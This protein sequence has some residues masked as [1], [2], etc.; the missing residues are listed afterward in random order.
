MTYLD[1]LHALTILDGTS[2][3]K[4]RGK[5]SSRIFSDQRWRRPGIHPLAHFQPFQHFRLILLSFVNHLAFQGAHMRIFDAKD[6]K[7]GRWTI[8]YNTTQY[9]YFAIYSIFTEILYECSLK[10]KLIELSYW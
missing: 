1:I 3:I 8:Q 2:N 10:L 4:F 9:F 5:L 6:C 7:T